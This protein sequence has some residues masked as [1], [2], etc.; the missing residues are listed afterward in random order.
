MT[1]TF[2]RTF[3]QAG[4]LLPLASLLLLGAPAA[5]AQT[6]PGAL[7]STQPINPSVGLPTITASFNHTEVD[8][9]AGTAYNFNYYDFSITGFQNVGASNRDYYSI[10][11]FS[12][13]TLEKQPGVVGVASAY[14]P[15]GW[16]F[17]DSHDFDISVGLIGIQPDDPQF[18]LIFIQSLGT[19]PINPTG[20]PFTVFHQNGGVQPF[21]LNGNNVTVPVNAPVPEAPASLSFGLLLALGLGGVLAARRQRG[22]RNSG[23]EN[24]A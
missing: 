21:T 20:A 4:G 11:S 1:P 10:F 3:R 18:G 16:T 2:P 12:N 5:Q 14:L 23:A 9:I 13:S 24:R 15:P 22:A 19:T 8:R 6:P 17:D 7:G